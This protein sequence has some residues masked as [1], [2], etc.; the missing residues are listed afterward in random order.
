MIL[1]HSLYGHIE[2][3]EVGSVLRV[4]LPAR[5]HQPKEGGGALGREGQTLPVLD[6]I[7]DL[8]VLYSDKGFDP[9]H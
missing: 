8:V 6:P 3:A 7:D 4:I 1:S 2:F 5:V 9:S